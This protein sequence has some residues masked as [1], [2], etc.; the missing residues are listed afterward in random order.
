MEALWIFL[1]FCVI[2][3]VG[4]FFQGRHWMRSLERQYKLRGMASPQEV[5]HAAANAAKGLRWDVRET[6]EGCETE[7]DVGTTI[8]IKLDPEDDGGCTTTL[9]L[10]KIKYKYQ[11]G[12]LIKTP[13]AYRS[14][15]RRR[16]R[17]LTAVSATVGTDSWL[18]VQGLN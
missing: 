14:I 5:L 13:N 12:G 16:K 10:S 6:N 3:F 7:H 2:V 4:A 9:F 1:L 18:E 17:I 11:M 15:Q 8:Q